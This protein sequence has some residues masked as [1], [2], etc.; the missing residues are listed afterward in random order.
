MATGGSISINGN[1]SVRRTCTLN[2]MVEDIFDAEISNVRNL[3][4]IGRKIF[5]EIGISNNTGRYEEE[6]PIL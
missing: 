3:I 2:M 1:S 4:S 6:Y 5:L